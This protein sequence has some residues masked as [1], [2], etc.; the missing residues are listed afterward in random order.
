MKVYHMKKLLMRRRL[1]IVDEKNIRN[2]IVETDN[3]SVS[4]EEI[5]N[6]EKILDC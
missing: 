6:E 1:Q 3:G 4:Y 5:A 2:S